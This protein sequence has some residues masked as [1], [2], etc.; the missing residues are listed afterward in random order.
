MDTSNS[1]PADL[2]ARVIEAAEQ[3]YSDHGRE[4]M[5]TVSEVR[6][7]S[8]T[9]MNLTATV[10]REWKRQQTARPTLVAAPVPEQV[11]GAM[12]DALVSVWT[13]AQDLANASLNSAEQRWQIER[14]EIAS[15]LKEASG[16]VDRLEAENKTLIGRCH[17]ATLN[18]DDALEKS[19]QQEVEIQ[20][21]RELLSR[22]EALT[23]QAES[24]TAEVELRVDDLKAEL[25]LARDATKAVQEELKAARLSHLA[26]VEQNQTVAVAEI[27]RVSEQ[28]STAREASARLAGKLEALEADSTKIRADLEKNKNAA[29][30]KIARANEL[31][32]NSRQ[33]SAHL[34]AEARQES[35]RLVAEARQ[36]SARMAGKL[37]S[38]EAVLAR[39]A[40]AKAKSKD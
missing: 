9:D 21:L 31:V 38:L 3:L 24:V 23:A 12:D 26:V 10:V 18:L 29:D 6:A 17:A 20:R 16:V 5:P 8:R 7:V 34:V 27:A 32:S 40:P 19:E 4:R 25:T 1:I 33:E 11:R 39:L 36:E 22:Q 2:R 28:L 13:A 30:D 35:A 37:E 15:D 14:E